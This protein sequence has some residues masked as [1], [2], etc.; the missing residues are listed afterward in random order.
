M[1]LVRHDACTMATVHACTTEGGI[2][3]AMVKI[4]FL[5]QMFGV[6]LIKF[7]GFQ[8]ILM[9]LAVWAAFLSWNG[10]EIIPKYGRGGGFLNILGCDR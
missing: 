1:I 9:V 6:I 10:V 7:Y 4:Q 2:F 3:E 8:A 5:F